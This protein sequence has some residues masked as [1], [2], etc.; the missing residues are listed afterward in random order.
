MEQDQGWTKERTATLHEVRNAL[1]VVDGDLWDNSSSSYNGVRDRVEVSLAEKSRS[2]LKLIEV[3]NFQI[4][5]DIEGAAF[6]NAK[7][8]VRGMFSLNG[9]QYSLAI[10]DPAVERVYLASNND[11]YNVGKA[12]L[13]IS[14]GE[15]YQ[16]YAYKL[17]ASVIL[18]TK[19]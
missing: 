10:T 13:C 3:D 5:V 15:P 12:I 6:G 4:S 14:L 17:I 18:P 7:R 1:D 16:G 9:V 8:K 19:V 2:S 11:A